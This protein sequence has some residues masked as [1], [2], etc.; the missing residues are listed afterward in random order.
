[1]IRLLTPPRIAHS[2]SKI[3]SFSDRCQAIVRFCEKAYLSPDCS[4][5]QKEPFCQWCTQQLIKVL[6]DVD[7]NLS[8][9]SDRRT[10]CMFLDGSMD[11]SI[12]EVDLDSVG[13]AYVLRRRLSVRY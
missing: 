2:I 6:R 12:P 3:P 5:S 8:S 9:A 1:M 13:D 7:M 4:V 10:L 11:M